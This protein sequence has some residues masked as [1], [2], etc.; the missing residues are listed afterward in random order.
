MAV[1]AI[2]RSFNRDAKLSNSR[3]VFEQRQRTVA[4]AVEIQIGIGSRGL[5]CSG[6]CGVQ[7]SARRRLLPEFKSDPA[8]RAVKMRLDLGDQRMPSPE[9]WIVDLRA[10]Y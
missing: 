3:S 5:R 1:I 7:V 6:Y 9:G 2:D 4:L 8:V 10:E